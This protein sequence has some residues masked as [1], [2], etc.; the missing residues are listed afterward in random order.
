FNS[1]TDEVYSVVDT[2]GGT[3]GL[4]F[5]GRTFPLR[6]TGPSTFSVSGF[7]VSVAFTVGETGP[8]P[9]LRL[10][11]GGENRPGAVRFTP[12]APA[13]DSQR[14]YVGRYDSPELGASWSVAVEKDHLVVSGPIPAVE[15]AGAL[16]PAMADAF[17]APGAFMQFTRDQTGRV[18]GFALSAS[19]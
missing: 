12:A 10:Q 6:A 3:P 5:S 16:T 2:G 13:P 7:P 11:V 8:A 1:T 9:A 17:T 14:A 15:I 18:T 4:K 19:R